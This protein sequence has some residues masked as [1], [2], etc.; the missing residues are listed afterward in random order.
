[1]P[2]I[3]QIEW[4]GRIIA[5][6][7]LC[8]VVVWVIAG[9]KTKAVVHRESVAS[10]S[11]YILLLLISV[12]LLLAARRSPVGVALR[13]LG[14]AGAWLYVRFIRLYIGAVWIGAPLVLV[15]VLIAIWARVH[16]GG[17]WSG[18]ITLKQ[19]HELV[20]TG[21][22]RFVRHPIYTGMLLAVA[23][24]ALAI[25]QLRGALAFA[26]TLY[27]LWRK[28]RTEERLMTDTFGET[29]R[30]YCREVRALIPYL[31]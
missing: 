20:R 3:E 25:G 10:R 8:W 4:A 28:S 17:N 13:G 7:W 16:L 27:A 29:Y 14:P 12:L 5:A 22:Y 24:T 30:R 18:M 21:P 11:T 1:M 23:G 6:V 31:L 2:R 19:H 9:L 15:G 26:L